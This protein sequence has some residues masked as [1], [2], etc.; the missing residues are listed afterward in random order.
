MMNFSMKREDNERYEPMDLMLRGAEA[1]EELKRKVLAAMTER[2]RENEKKAQ[3]KKKARKAFALRAAVIAAAIVTVAAATP[4]RGYVASAAES[5]WNAFHSWMDDA[6]HVGMKKT[7]HGYSMEIID[8]RV[9]NDFLY[10][11]TYDNLDDCL[12]DFEGRIDD[13]KGNQRS[14]S[15]KNMS[16]SVYER[17]PGKKVYS[18]VIPDLNTLISS[19][20]KQYTCR[21][22]INAHQESAI[23][24]EEDRTA[25]F[26]FKFKI[27]NI[28]SVIQV[29]EMHS[30]DM[31]TIGDIDFKSWKLVATASEVYMLAE[32]ELNEPNAPYR[33]ESIFAGLRMV[34]LMD[35]Q[36]YIMDNGDTFE[37]VSGWPCHSNGK[38][39]LVL[40]L[41]EPYFSDGEAYDE[42]IRLKELTVPKTYQITACRIFNT[43]GYEPLCTAEYD[44]ELQT[45]VYYDDD[46]SLV[47][48]PYAKELS[49]TITFD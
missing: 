11:T 21:L 39:Y 27:K 3:E 35:R 41:Y 44:E 31:I 18:I 25:S 12:V 23:G 36:P 29:T 26:S 13:N 10:F 34:G 45:Y 16:G 42:F 7:S 49:Q 40:Y 24:R 43:E 48:S 32:Y 5:A 47:E 9:S 6:F 4:M 19:Y 15:V 22:T 14:F 2:R 1:P 38:S 8:A 37:L 46:D 20:S 17:L 30:N 33:E 28:D